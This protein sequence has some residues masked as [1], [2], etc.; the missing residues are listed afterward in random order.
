MRLDALRDDRQRIR[1]GERREDVAPLPAGPAGEAHPDATHVVAADRPVRISLRG[2][3][4][5]RPPLSRG[6]SLVEEH[7]AV[8]WSSAVTP[9]EQ[10][11]DRRPD[12]ELE[13]HD[14]RHR[15]AG[16]AEQEHRAIAIRAPGWA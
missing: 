15:V 7:A 4:Q 8:A 13:R 16:E 12:E 6:P 1:R 3:A 9:A 10:R 11:E 14:R 2:D 5:E